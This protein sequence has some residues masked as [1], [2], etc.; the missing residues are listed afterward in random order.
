MVRPMA[1]PVTAE[2]WL[3]LYGLSTDPCIAQDR[4]YNPIDGRGLKKPVS[5][6][7]AFAELIDVVRAY[8][9]ARSMSARI[10]CQPMRSVY[11]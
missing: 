4:T 11:C 7:K 10:T 8:V 6:E 9:E 3:L 5:K 1:Q 2:V